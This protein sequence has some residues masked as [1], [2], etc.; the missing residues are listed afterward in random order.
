MEKKELLY[1][2]LLYLKEQINQNFFQSYIHEHY[3]C[4]ENKDADQL[5]GN[6]KADL[7]LF[8]ACADCWFSHEAA[9]I[10]E[11]KKSYSMNCFCT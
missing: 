11:K 1:E 2:L 3:M 8:F 7:R 10:M 9:Q 5:R 4:S 6:R